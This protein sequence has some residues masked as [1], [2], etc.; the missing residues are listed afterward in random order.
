MEKKP[1]KKSITQI[2]EICTRS[3][4]TQAYPTTEGGKNHMASLVLSNLIYDTI[5]LSTFSKSLTMP[6]LWVADLVIC[7]F[8][9]SK[10]P[11]RPPS[12]Q[13]AAQ[14]AS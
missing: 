1:D 5:I 8:E 11:V 13:D 10:Y 14:Y 7:S 9:P 3:W 12:A 6:H 4:Q 2:A